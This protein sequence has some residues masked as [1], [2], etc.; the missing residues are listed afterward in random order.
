MLLLHLSDIHFRRDMVNTTLDPD[1]RQR[2]EILR[3]VEAMCAQL[4]SPV[5]AILL[6]GD[7]AYSGHADEYKFAEKWLE[8]LCQRCEAT[9][10]D[11][12][13][14]PG[15]HDVARDIAGRNIIQALHQDI[16]SSADLTL[17]AK[18]RGLLTD[19]E[20]ARLLYEPLNAYNLFAGQFFCDL[21]PPQRTI[22][23]RDLTLNDR[24]TL[25]LSGLNSAFVSSAADRPETLFVD[26][27]YT[28]LGRIAGVEH[29]VMCH[30]P[31]HW[32]RRGRA[33]EDALNDVARLHL[34]GHEHRLRI[35]LARDWVRIAAAATHPD[36][37][38]MGWEPGYN[39][40]EVSVQGTPLDRRLLIGAHLRVW[41]ESP[42]RF[43]AKIDRTNEPVFRSEIKLDP[44]EAP[45]RVQAPPVEAVNASTSNDS[46]QTSGD[47]MNPLRELSIRFF[48]LTLSQKSAIAGKLGLLEDEDVNQP[49]F[50]RFRRVFVRARDRGLITKL[51]EEVSAASQGS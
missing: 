47:P 7:V 28:Q 4:G 9:L 38:E 16:K 15:N 5:Q 43:V 24:S 25:R 48:K 31:L 27:A 18:L 12:F 26:P 3:D 19:E 49:D 1:Q 22:A 35:T 14:C 11:I 21:L 13:V 50:E 29:L 51:A 2:E 46:E 32:L 44:W 17:D 37:T 10:S 40:I 36:R 23:C 6:S 30:H 8:A 42:G 39:L 45:S 41:Q 33:L 20:T 34:F